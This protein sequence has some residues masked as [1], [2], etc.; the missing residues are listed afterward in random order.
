L[1][2]NG[3]LK[4]FEPVK[5]LSGFI[6]LSELE[7]IT[8]SKLEND[9]FIKNNYLAVPQMDIRSSAA[10]FSVNGK[11]SFNN[12]YEYHVKVYLSEI[13]SKKAKS[14]SR[15]STEFGPVE[16]DGLGRTS[17][18]L[19]LTGTGEDVKVTADMKATR[20]NIKQN[21]N[22][23]KGTLKNILNEEYGWFKSDT[24][25]KPGATSKPK[26]KIQFEETDTTSVQKDTVATDESKGI[27]RIFRRKKGS[28]QKF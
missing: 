21:L 9:L 12:E 27:N 16:E 24:T 7:N 5:A 20:N 28:D 22:K 15:Y 13:L 8:F 1:I 25:V 10:D 6:E 18:F 2:E 4:N 3:A 23:E 19:K 11:H 26:F 14:N 17:I